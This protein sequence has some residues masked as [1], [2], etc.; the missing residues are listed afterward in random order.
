MRK[1]RKHPEY[2]G[3]HTTYRHHRN[4]LRDTNSLQQDI[5]TQYNGNYKLVPLHH[6]TTETAALHLQLNRHWQFPMNPNYCTSRPP[7]API[8]LDRQCQ[9]LLLS[10]QNKLIHA[11]AFT[12]RGCSEKSHPCFG[13]F[14]T[15]PS[16]HW[17]PSALLSI[18]KAFQVTFQLTQSHISA[19]TWFNMIAMHH[20]VWLGFSCLFSPRNPCNL[21]L[22]AATVNIRFHRIFLFSLFFSFQRGG[23]K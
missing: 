17:P 18:L 21:N 12:S 14:T 22:P 8:L 7:A 2:D 15:T 9:I 13:G 11:Y 20:E 19:M 16:S 5:Q 3:H 23:A 1:K 4:S 6:S 10:F